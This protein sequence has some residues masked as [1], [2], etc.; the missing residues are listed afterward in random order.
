MKAPAERP[1]NWRT[2]IARLH[3]NG[4]TRAWMNLDDVKAMTKLTRSRRRP[5]GVRG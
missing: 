5:R 3:P 4:I 2:R 1:L